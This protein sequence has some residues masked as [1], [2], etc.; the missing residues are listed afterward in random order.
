MCVSMYME[1]DTYSEPGPPGTYAAFGPARAVPPPHPGGLAETSVTALYHDHALDLIRL[2][3]VM[4]GD[5]PSAED[6]VQDAFCALYRRWGHLSEPASALRYVR[7]SVLNGCRTV[8][9][10]R[11][12]RD[13]YRD[14]A[15]AASA[16]TAV[17]N[18]EERREV[19]RAV[20]RLPR[21]QREALVLRFYLDLPDQEIA[22]TMGIG[23]SSVR[24]ATHR[25]LAAL[26]R[27]LR[28]SS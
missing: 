24:S 9:R 8:L 4:L 21:R 20:R 19:M 14:C 26:G 22:A 13:P 25:A 28:E 16:E 10:K 27:T 2:A 5:R 3:H 17:L 11:A 7:A 12:R 6:V 15:P 18:G 23:Q 1:P